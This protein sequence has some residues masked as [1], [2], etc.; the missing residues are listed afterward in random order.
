[1]VKYEWSDR[2]W[3]RV[4][5]NESRR[6]QPVR[7][8]PSPESLMGP[9]YPPRLCRSTVRNTKRPLSTEPLVAQRRNG[10]DTPRASADQV[11]WLSI[12][13]KG[14]NNRFLRL[15]VN[16]AARVSIRCLASLRPSMHPFKV[17]RLIFAEIDDQFTRARTLTIGNSSEE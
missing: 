2:Y 16:C 15:S 3:Q 17:S 6:Q 7:Y 10:P 8:I 13:P 5:M 11:R 14:T 4:G 1:V 12:K 9:E